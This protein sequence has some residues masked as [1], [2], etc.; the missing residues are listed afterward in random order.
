MKKGYFLTA[1]ITVFCLKILFYNAAYAEN[2]LIEA[3]KQNYNAAANLVTFEGNV[4]ASLN[5][6]TVKSSRASLKSGKD[7]K[8]EMA[9]FSQGAE[10]VKNDTTSK[11][12][13]KANIIRYSLLDNHISAE[14]N[15]G[16]SILE[17]QKPVITIKADSQEFDIANNLI[18][19]Q[20]HVAINYKDIETSSSNARIS[21]NKAGQPEKVHISG[22]AKLIQGKNIITASSFIYDPT[23]ETLIAS[24]NTHSQT[25]LDDASKVLVWSEN[26]YY[27]KKSNTLTASGNVKINYKDYTASGPKASFLPDEKTLK[28]NRIIFTGRSKIKESLKQL[29]A[30]KIEIIMNPKSFNA[31]GNVKTRFTQIRNPDKA[32]T[33]NSEKKEIKSPQK[34]LIPVKNEKKETEQTFQTVE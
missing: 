5:N 31:E 18:A 8:P 15:T 10:A 12:K 27:D 16:S 4:K 34:P 7:G 6:V 2:I 25:V 30:D 20:G 13:L 26:Q 29:D 11:S 17:N 23:L 19:A 33:K 14:G 3:D 9:E 24:G 28:P 1:I 21:I 22:S 32:V